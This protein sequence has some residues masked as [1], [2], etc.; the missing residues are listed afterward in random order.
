MKVFVTG[1]R[2]YIGSHVVDVLKQE[3]HTVIG[4]DINLFEGCNWEPMVKAD[5]ELV[6]DARKI[7]AAV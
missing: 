6:K 4:C 1:H 7:E 3:G 5:R 2:G